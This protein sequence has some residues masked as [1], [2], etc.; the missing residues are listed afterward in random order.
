MGNHRIGR[1][2]ILLV[3]MLVSLHG[4]AWASGDPSQTGPKTER[5]FPPLVVPPGFKATLFACDPMVE[6][7][8]VIARGPRPA[9]V[10]VAHDDLTGL[11]TQIARRDEIRLVEDTDGDGYADKSTVFAGGFNSIQGLASH[12]GHVF[13]MHAPL[14]TVL[15]DTDGD[16][17]ADERRDLLSGLGLPPEQDTLR[18]HNANGVV[19]GHDGWLYLAV[20]DHGVDVVRPEGD[21]L[22][23]HGGGILRCRPDGRDLHVFATGLRNI[24]DVALDEELNVFVRDNE[25]D[26]GDYMIRVCHSFHGADHGYPYGYYEHPEETLP[27]LADLG[28]GSSAGGV[29]YLETAFPPEFRGNLFFCEWG[30]SI[31]RYE[32]Q[33]LGSSFAPMKEMA[34]ATGAATDPYGF[35]PTDVIVDRDGSLLVSD[36]GD[37]QRPKRGRGRL[38]RISYIGRSDVKSGRTPRREPEIDPTIGP[39]DSPSYDSRVAAQEALERKGRDGLAMVRRALQD[40]RLGPLGRMHAVWVM[41]HLGGREC[42]SD[43]LSLAQSDADPRVRGQAVRAIADLSDPA[44]GPHPNQPASAEVATARRLS[45]LAARQDPPVVLEIVVALGRLRWR[46]VPGW[47]RDHLQDPDAALAH[48]ALQALR[49]AADWPAVLKLLDEPDGR[50]IRRI[51]L[52]AVAGQADPVIVD[53]LIDRLRAEKNPERRRR[54]ADALT[55]VHKKPGPWTYWGYRPPPRPVNVVAWERTEAIE[56]VLDEL[57]ADPDPGV[58]AAI[59]KRMQRERIPV[60]IAG[61]GRWLQQERTPDRVQ[62]ILDSLSRFPPGETRELLEGV[63]REPGYPLNNREAALALLIGG[64]DAASESRLRGLVDRVEDGPL[65]VALLRTLGNRPAIDSRQLLVRKLNSPDGNVR[66]AA[67]DTAAVLHVSEAARRIP[68][69]LRDRDVGVR[70]AAAAAAG[71][72]AAKESIAALSLLSRDADPAVRGASLESLRQL[73]DPTAVTAALGALD[74]PTTQLAAIDYLAAFGSPEQAGALVAVA[75]RSRR[76]DVLTGVVRAL[77]GWE[78]RQPAGSPHGRELARAV[79]EVQGQSGVLLWW[80]VTGPLPASAAAKLCDARSPRVAIPSDARSLLADGPESRIDLDRLPVDRSGLVWLAIS[81]IRIAEPVRA[82][83]LASAGAAVQV[84]VNGRSAFRREQGAA[85]QPDGDRFEVQL[86]RGDNQVVVRLHA[87]KPVAFHVRFRPLSSS[88]EHERI[89]QFVLRNNG[90][91][92]RGAAIFRNDEKSLCAKCHRIGDRGNRVG[93]DLTGVGERFSRIHLIESVLE[94]SRTIAPGYESV[95][96]VL[97]DGRV[98]TGVK[99][100]EDETTLTL[101]DETGKRREIRKLDIEERAPGR[102][103]IMPDGLEKRLTD[104]ELLDLLTYLL[105][106]RR[107]RAPSNGR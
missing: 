102:R 5:R 7:P 48:A 36:W 78:A 23:L 64:L 106:Q 17:V 89:A 60:G 99:M 95:A 71:A 32:R 19:V 49:R 104:R 3:C 43:L 8:S 22:V 20:G 40:H 75:S 88:A 28:R 52:A 14:L 54:Y 41:A 45:E 38:Y 13:A 62:A 86:A 11:G 66:A 92:E 100:A 55:R 21:R 61:L 35:K 26:G 83:F 67:L 63:V 79:A 77:A 107:P 42:V 101:G 53:G 70:R 34:F 82:Q 39:L 57:L 81:D 85:F 76:I 12:A 90:S 24:Y 33:R 58:R 44:L 68:E 73:G 98:V 91:V 105:A 96:A 103:S 69:L 37:D 46:A 87:G 93:P 72:L 94:P 10:F 25:N 97:A 31:V 9:S 15:R 16:G 65:L 2:T 30:R 59:L 29:C 74:H 51:A 47:L 80:H 84:D 4:R 27:P 18:L 1:T 50:P 6:Y 56:R